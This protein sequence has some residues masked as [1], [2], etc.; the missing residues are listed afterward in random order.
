M[1]AAREALT[2]SSNILSRLRL[3]PGRDGGGLSVGDQGPGPP[4]FKVQ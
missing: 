2:T 3:Q 4:P 1:T